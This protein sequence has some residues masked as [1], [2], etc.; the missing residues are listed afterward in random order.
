MLF[1][2]ALLLWLF[3]PPKEESLPQ[4]PDFYRKLPLIEPADDTAA[5]ADAYVRA[6][7]GG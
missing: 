7:G 2:I 6:G 5:I 4:P 1:W 3:E